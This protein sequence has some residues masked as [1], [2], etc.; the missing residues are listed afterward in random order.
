MTSER[1]LFV[2]LAFESGKEVPAIGLLKML[3]RGVIESGQFAYGKNYLTLPE[4]VS[5]NEDYLSLNHA[6]YELPERRL[7]G[8]GALP[9]TFRDALPDKWGRLVLQTQHG[10]HLDDIDVLLMTNA[11]RVGAMVF[12]ESNPI[13][14]GSGDEILMPLEELS[15]AVLRV[16]RQMEI[17]PAMR[18][19]LQR[20]GSLGGARPKATFIHGNARWIAKFPALGDTHDVELLEASILKLAELCGIDVPA[21]RLEKINRGHALLIRRFDREGEVGSERRLHY[22]SASALLDV[23]YESSGGSYVELAQFLRR[24]ALNPTRDLEQLYKRMIFNLVID[25]T[26]D[27]VKNHGALLA[28]QMRY[29]LA[30]AFDM[31]MQ[32]TNTGYQELAI[33][34]GNNSS[35][36]KLAKEVAAQFG[37]KQDAAE[38][39]IQSIYKI[40]DANLTQLIKQFGGDEVLIRRVEKCLKVQLGMISSW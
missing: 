25:N 33:A 38:E 10:K 12:S 22:L 2:G 21:S 19:L 31:V 11:D 17:T 18:R 6:I 35:S 7:R 34:P 28:G 15:E 39:I 40:V 23:P 13:D 8:G 27:H 1:K 30:P 9:L 3:R 32:L 4:A 24:F 5:L 36:I 20:G 16:E 14:T 26:D 29:R 37:I